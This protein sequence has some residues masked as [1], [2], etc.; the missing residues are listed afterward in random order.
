MG[1]LLRVRE[2]VW[3]GG[4]VTCFEWQ[5]EADSP[6]CQWRQQV[7]QCG[8]CDDDLQIRII[9]MMQEQE[10][11]T[12][13][14]GV[15]DFW[16]RKKKA[17]GTNV[18]PSAGSWPGR[19]GRGSHMTSRRHSAVNRR[20]RTFRW[21]LIRCLKKS[22]ELIDRFKPTSEICLLFKEWISQSNISL[23]LVVVLVV[24]APPQIRRQYDGILLTLSIF[25]LL[26]ICYIL[27]K[28]LQI[29]CLFK[30]FFEV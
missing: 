6:V 29:Y 12:R 3:G 2:R 17:H 26:K 4:G 10:V 1:V 28:I 16:K 27:W 21:C 25:L 14:A 24:V 13:L 18:A 30:V 7:E 20:F 22:A 15:E 19:W 23:L 9:M 8:D 5:R 11:A